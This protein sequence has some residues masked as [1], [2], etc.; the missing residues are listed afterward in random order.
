MTRYLQR[1]PNLWLALALLLFG[2]RPGWSQSII[3]ASNVQQ[4]TAQPASGSVRQLKD[5][6]NELNG[7]YGV[8]ILFELR[9]VD[10]LSVA[11]ETISPKATL[12]KT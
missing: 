7:R 3:L 12:E 2:L 10:D 9:V 8:N 1:F 4:S 5:V 6:L 11:T